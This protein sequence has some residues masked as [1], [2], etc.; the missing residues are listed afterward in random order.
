MKADAGLVAVAE[1][2]AREQPD[3][4]AQPFHYRG[5]F[6]ELSI[7]SAHG[8]KALGLLNFDPRTKMP[9]HFH[10]ARDTMANIDLDVLARSER[11]AWAILQKLDRG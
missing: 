7:A 8:Q 11:F 5:L 9:P 1:Q 4:G 10:T 6:S 2:V 3:L